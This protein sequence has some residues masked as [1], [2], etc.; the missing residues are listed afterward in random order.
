MF[1]H[2]RRTSVG[3]PPFKLFTFPM[4]CR[5]KLQRAVHDNALDGPIRAQLFQTYYDL[6]DCLPGQLF[7]GRQA[8]LDHAL[9]DTVG[10]PEITRR[11]EA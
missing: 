10:D 7:P 2:N 5:P 11:T 6:T 8:A 3:L 4:R 1:L 9:I